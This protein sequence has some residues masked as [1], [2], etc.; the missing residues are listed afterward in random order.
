MFG[1]A[2][3]KLFSE[4]LVLKGR[5][6]INLILKLWG[7]NAGSVDVIGCTAKIIQ[8]PLRIEWR[9]AAILVLIAIEIICVQTNDL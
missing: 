8:N 9:C 6:G 3:Q 4:L 2:C 5:F 1:D 7:V